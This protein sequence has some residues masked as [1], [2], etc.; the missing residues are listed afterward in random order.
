MKY[1]CTNCNAEYLR[2]A[3]KCSSC[4]EWDSLVEV[5]DESPKSKSSKNGGVA[6]YKQI[7]EYKKGDSA[8]ASR[9][10]TGF[11][12]FNRVLGGGIVEGSISLIAG[13]PGVGKSTL[14]SQVAINVCS[15][16]KVLY[17]SG[18]ESGTQIYS[19]VSRLAN[20]RPH[21]NLFVCEDTQIERIYEA[22][23]QNDP[24]LIIVDSI[25]SL[26]SETVRSYAGSVGQVRVCGAMLMRMAKEL[27]VAVLVIGQITKEG[28]VAGPKVLEHIVDTVLYI[29]GGE[30]SQFRILRAAKNRFG[31]TDEIGVFEMGT[32]GLIQV[33]NPSQA[34]LEKDDWGEGSALGAVLKGSRVVMIEVQALVAER[35]SE[36]G[37]LRRVA[38]GIKKPRLDMLC[39]VVS[40]RGGV[41][42]G[43][44]D[45]FVN[46][47]GG[48][49]VD[50][51]SLDL[52]ICQ[53]IK[54]ASVDKILDSN[55]VFF[56]EVSLN[57]GIR[58]GY[59]FKLIEKEC[60]R[61]GYKVISRS[62]KA[63]SLKNI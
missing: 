22:V 41:Y 15:N 19:R 1:F 59:S 63:L 12:E 37:P 25:Q 6:V 55:S 27:N 7:S 14:L 50:D 36:G 32:S 56:G 53:A 46:V 3:G 31:A 18:E 54:A 23:V 28:N 51:P 4:G 33:E 24:K 58:K 43:D 57:G 49:E 17:V 29:E 5:E 38:N 34:F 2:W 35:G 30:Y 9:I 8:I 47:V 52:A 26:S 48:V 13:E 45:V 62:G 44:K 42:L 39:A 21:S 16:D 61:L 11:S 60:K 20:N 10:D 40:R